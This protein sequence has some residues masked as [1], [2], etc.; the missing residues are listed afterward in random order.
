MQNHQVST[1]IDLV[2]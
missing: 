1:Y 2:N